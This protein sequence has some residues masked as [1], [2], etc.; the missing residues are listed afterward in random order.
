VTSHD[1]DTLRRIML[2]LKTKKKAG[3]RLSKDVAKGHGKMATVMVQQGADDGGGYW[4]ETQVVDKALKPYSNSP[5]EEDVYP[6]MGTSGMKSEVLKMMQLLDMGR[7]A[8]RKVSLNLVGGFR[9]KD[10]T[11]NEKGIRDAK[12]NRKRRQFELKGKT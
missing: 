6:E 7:E 12:R 11:P 10:L 2:L 9:G 4:P 3:Q 1:P 5:F 8:K